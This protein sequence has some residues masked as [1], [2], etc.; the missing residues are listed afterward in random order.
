MSHGSSVTKTSGGWPSFQTGKN[1]VPREPGQERIARGTARLPQFFDQVCDPAGVR[2]AYRC[3]AYP[4]Q[5]Q[6]QVLARTFGCVRVRSALIS[7]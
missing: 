2:T 5:A 4:D 1:P 6:Q 3:R 7:A